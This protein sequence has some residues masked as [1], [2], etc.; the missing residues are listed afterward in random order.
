MVALMFSNLLTY[1]EK[2]NVRQLEKNVNDVSLTALPAANVFR[3][4][5]ER[6]SSAITKTADG[7]YLTNSSASGAQRKMGSPESFEVSLVCCM[8]TTALTTLTQMKLDILTGL[9]VDE[10]ILPNLWQFISSLGPKNG[11]VSYLDHLVLATKATA[12]E[13]QMLILYTMIASH[14]IT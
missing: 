1:N 12:P 5:I 11:L 10:S 14:L 9:C 4:A 2:F 3:R 13:F 7:S 8:Y 6:A